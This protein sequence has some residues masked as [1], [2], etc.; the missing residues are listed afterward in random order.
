MKKDVLLSTHKAYKK[1]VKFNVAISD[2]SDVIS[3]AGKNH[4]NK[5]KKTNKKEEKA[6][7]KSNKQSKKEKKIK[8]KELKKQARK[9]KKNVA[10]CDREFDLNKY[11]S[12][13]KRYFAH[14]G[15]HI[16]YPENSM[17]AFNEAIKLNMAIELDV[18][19]TKDKQLIVFH[20]DNLERMA[21]VNEYV[22]FMTLSELQ[23][24]K[25][26]NTDYTIPSFK[27]VLDFVAGRVPILVEI[28]TEANTKKLC[29][30]LIE[31]LKGYKGE[32]FI[33][34]FNPFA[35]RYFYKHA[36]TYLRGQLSS[37][38]KGNKLGFFK[39]IL[40]KSLRLNGFA[41]VNFVAY[42]IDNLPNKYVNR[43]NI[44]VLT[45]TIKTKEQFVK[46]KIASNNLIIDNID[47]INTK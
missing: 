12:L 34:S 24:I 45:W 21:G 13:L 46:A 15:V 33:Q 19:L 39:R 38:F 26:D 41:H 17:P 35:L 14:R 27:Q 36:P 18:H 32:I 23:E 42:N 20:D 9:N 31:E 47:V 2:R 29:S 22:R 16:V 30:K 6:K 37:F 43:T 10:I 4:L 8:Q 1:D 5:D 3:L 7:Q 28:K 11:G 44:P 25:L 40:I